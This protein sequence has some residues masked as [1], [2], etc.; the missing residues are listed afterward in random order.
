MQFHVPSNGNF[1]GIGQGRN[2][3]DLLSWPAAQRNFP[4]ATPIFQPTPRP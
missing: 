2:G 1:A 3:I 4:F